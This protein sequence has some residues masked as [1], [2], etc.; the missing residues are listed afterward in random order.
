MTTAAGDRGFPEAAAELRFDAV[1]L[2]EEER[3]SGSQRSVVGHHAAKRFPAD[4][5]FE[6]EIDDR[7]EVRVSALFVD[8]ADELHHATDVRGV[9]EYLRVEKAAVRGIVGFA[10]DD[11]ALRGEIE[12]VAD[13]DP[14][15]RRAVH[16][17]S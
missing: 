17:M 13:V 8:D 5:L 14:H 7:L 1:V 3:L 15:W 11:V 12:H 10:G 16:P 9:A 4:G 6:F 2:R